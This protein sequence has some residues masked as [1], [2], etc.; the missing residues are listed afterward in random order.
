MPVPRPARPS[1]D[2]SAGHRRGPPATSPPENPTAGA[3]FSVRHVAKATQI[4]G[5]TL[6]RQLAAPPEAALARG[7]TPHGEAAGPPHGGRPR[8]A[9]RP[10]PGSHCVRV[11]SLCACGYIIM[12]G[13]TAVCSLCV[14]SSLRSA[15]RPPPTQTDPTAGGVKLG[16]VVAAPASVDPPKNLGPPPGG[17]VPRRRHGHHI[18]SVCVLCARLHCHRRPV[19]LC[20]SLCV[21]VAKTG[22]RPS[23]R[24]Y[25]VTVPT[26]C[27]RAVILS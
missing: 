11:R 2:F 25:I 12:T 19:C 4:K 5:H 15:S 3:G 7:D 24:S 14:W 20:M 9:S 6:F 10:S 8:S 17:W 13:C 18:V 22:A 26:S 21:A 27:V 1:R 23:P 16:P